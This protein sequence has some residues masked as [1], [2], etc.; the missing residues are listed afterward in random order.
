MPGPRQWWLRLQSLVNRS[1]VEGD[2]ND[3]IRDYLEREM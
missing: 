2:L 1:R 3:E